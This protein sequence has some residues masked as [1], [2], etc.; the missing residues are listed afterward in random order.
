MSPSVSTVK[1][2]GLSIGSVTEKKVRNGPA[3][4]TAAASSISAPT[5]CSAARKSSMKVPDVVKIARMMSTHIATEGPANQS[6]QLKPSGPSAAAAPDPSTPTAPSSR[7]S[8]PR[9]SENQLGPSAPSQPST[10][11]TAPDEVKRKMKI[12]VIAI[13]LVTDGK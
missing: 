6:H 7:C 10:W 4:S 13:E 5:F 2:V 8:T 1:S 3:P 9:G 12:V 11:L